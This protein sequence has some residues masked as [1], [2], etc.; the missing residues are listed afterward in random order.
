MAIASERA[1]LRPE[2]AAPTPDLA[3]RGYTWRQVRMAALVVFVAA[4]A[5]SIALYGIPLD[6]V[7]L[8]LWILVGLSVAVIGKGWGA[9]LRIM[10]DWLPFQGVLLAYDYSYGIAGRY[11]SGGHPQE[12]DTNVIGM[13][14]HV[15][16]PVDA[17]KAMFGGTLPN[18]WVQEHFASGS[19]V[20]WY[21]ALVT[22]VYCSHFVVTPLVAA[23]LWVR[24]REKFRTW[25]SLVLALAV[26]GLA[27]Y[28][29]FPMSPPWLAS[30]QGVIDGAPVERITGDG[31]SVLGLHIAGQVLDD[32]QA[33]SNPVGAMPSL[34]MAYAVLAAV[35]FMFLTR[36]RWLRWLL[37]AYPLAMAFSL[38]YSG[39]HYVVDEI[40]GAVYA[41]VVIA[42]WRMW[43]RRRES[44]DA[45]RASARE[46]SDREALLGASD[47]SAHVVERGR[48][49]ADPVATERH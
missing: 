34:H 22:L 27:T 9:W 23:G 20:P 14:L 45:A 36:R 29:L 19:G 31:W 41:L 35:F 37:A 49:E 48:R 12:G 10:R 38:V 39:E 5:A 4:L 3:F 33:R 30:Q 46:V 1:P 21:A 42:G 28:F 18:Q 6:R 16:F 44:L 43:R 15:S 17:D 32:S 7:G 2:A 26:A 40:A 8:T 11:G 13:P 25:V 24:A 47:G